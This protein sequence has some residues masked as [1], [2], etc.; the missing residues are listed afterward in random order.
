MSRLRLHYRLG[1]DLGTNS[2]GW[3]VLVLDR[4]NQPIR[5]HSAGS[6]IFS[7]GR[8]PKSG[9]SLANDRRDAR[10]MRRRRDRF[11]RR[12]AA[13]LKH[14][15][16]AGFFPESESE[17]KALQ[18]LDPFAL[19]A[20]AL[21]E[22]LG[23]HEIGRAFFHLNQ[24][25][26]F[27]SNRRADNKDGED[28][29][30]A[31]GIDRLRTAIV[32]TG[33]RT[34]GEF[35]HKR[36]M[37]AETQSAVPPVRTRLRAEN[38]EV[39]KGDG[40]DFYPSRALLEEEF[41]DIWEAQAAHY[42]EIMTT[43][44]YNRL[45]EVVFHQRPLKAPRVGQCTLLEGAR[46]PKAHPLFQKRRLLEEINALRIVRVGQVAETLT[47][48]QRDLLFLK[49]KDQRKSAFTALRKELKLERQARFNKE[50]ENRKDLAGDEVA[51]ELGAK[52]RFANRW[53]HFSWQQQ[54]EI[55]SRLRA[56]ESEQ[57]EAACLR[58]LM[59]TF[60]LE[61]ERGRA[62]LGAHLPQGYGRFGLE[63][64][65]RL[66]EA[67]EAD[68]IT[69]DKAVIAAGLGHHSDFPTGEVFEDDSGNPA[70]P[71]YGVALE[72]HI[73]PGTADPDDKDEASRVGRITNPTVHIG[74]NQLRRLVNALIR[75]YGRPAQI[76][77]ELARELK[78][79]EDEK[80]EVNGR[81]TKNRREAEKRSEKL[82]EL[83]QVDNGA[84]RALLKLW[85]ELNPE[86]A[87]DRRCVYT[88]QQISIEMLFS[89][90]VEIDHILP[91]D[92]T[93]DDSNANKI[94]CLREANRLKRKRSPHEAWGHTA[95]WE[96]IAAR[97]ARLPREKRWRFEPDAMKRFDDQGGFLARHLVDTQYLA[98]RAR[99]YLS[100][101]YPSEG[102]GSSHVWV[103]PGR[104]TEMVRRKL[105]LNDL[106]P[107]H[108]FSGGADQPKNRLDH[109]HHAIDAAVIGIVDRG[110]LQRIAFASGKNGAEGRERI[111]VPPPWEGFR[112]ELRKVVNAIVVSHR[113][114]HGTV[115]KSGLPNGRDQT[116]AR[117][118]NDTAYGLTGE[119]DAKGDAIVVHRVPLTSL[120]PEHFDPDSSVVVRDPDLRDALRHFTQGKEGK[121][122]LQ[123]LNRFPELG[124]LQ[125]RGVRHIRLVKPLNVIEIQD[126]NGKPY[127]GYKGDSNY[128]YDVWELPDGKWKAEVVSMF[129]AHQ[130]GWVSD[131]RKVYPTARKVL[132]LQQ[133]DMLAIER[134]GEREL[135]RVV[136]FSESQL[137][138]AHPHE[139]GSLKAR[140]ADKEDPF[141]YIYPSPSGLNKWQARQVRI[142]E[143]GRVLDPG[144]PP[145]KPK[146][147]T[148]TG[149]T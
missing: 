45:F 83:G 146:S 81:N 66:I 136:K 129:A 98:K 26:G 104:L 103:S 55:I 102:E 34:F 74:L 75:A 7:D 117:L 85:E 19:R 8:D 64:T 79:S 78:L 65:Q 99:E 15:T 50:S 114:D 43:E 2:L 5:I 127:K 109:R 106:L 118:H 1:L 110:L 72:R 28:G 40:Y 13:L 21:D 84:N 22:K 23:L 120:K 35:L 56:V 11:L 131:I 70:L 17:R 62:I 42:P 31:I 140:D 111:H 123:A 134:T 48:E 57:D 138:V 88:G 89:S 101:L 59:T 30:I 58:W 9:A 121:E 27:K 80:K 20:R 12:R 116:A 125:F 143:L 119:K 126:R 38:G 39:A 54:W 92:A 113:V 63:A 77:L 148:I 68:V 24:R 3:C 132:S 37:S 105:G 10:A 53:A 47:R 94:I 87:L 100:T 91:F 124:P 115:A 122:Y 97:A 90:A 130:S 133:N 16:A 32:E 108:N 82:R 36:R 142:D 25:R 93:L 51:A 61:E 41:T 60:E 139:S 73:T 137:A 71:Y 14:L 69:Y 46:L 145:R 67:L 128:R 44:V 107:D 95:E 29:K 6:R 144:F 96:D 149:Q 4:N 147:T 76:A 49:L 112:D 33:A 18:S 135:V 141:K 52:G 86:N